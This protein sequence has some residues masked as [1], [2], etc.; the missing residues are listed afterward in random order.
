M[1]YEDFAD[2]LFGFMRNLN[3]A[4][5]SGNAETVLLD[6]FND[7]PL[8]NAII[9]HMRVSRIHREQDLTDMMTDSHC[10]MD[11]DTPRGIHQLH[12]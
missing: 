10:C 2:E 3:E 1:V 6:G 7:E 5:T 9:T 12:S 11:E 4:V 8:Q